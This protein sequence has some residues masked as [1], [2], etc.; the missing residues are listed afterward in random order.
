MGG[1]SENDSKTKG[2]EKIL[3]LLWV[4][5]QLFPSKF[6]EC[7]GLVYQVGCK[8]PLGQQNVFS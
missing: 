5:Q 3:K 8:G 1:E 7:L 4:K 2:E 6:K